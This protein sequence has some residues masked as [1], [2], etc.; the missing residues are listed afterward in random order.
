MGLVLWFGLSKSETSEGVHRMKG[1][2]D[3]LNDVS[4]VTCIYFERKSKLST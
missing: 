2:S 4:V 3:M 1:N